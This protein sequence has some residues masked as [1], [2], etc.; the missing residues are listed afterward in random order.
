VSDTGQRKTSVSELNRDRGGANSPS[1][2]MRA[3]RPEL[4]S[5][6]K[7]RTESL[8]NKEALDYHLGVLT[9]KKQEIDFEHFC[10]RIAEQEI[11][12]N[13]IAQ[14]GPTGGGDSKVDSENYPVSERISI[15]WYQGIPNDSAERWAFAFSAKREWRS[16]VRADV[17]SVASTKRGYK[18]IYFITNQYVKD[19]SRAQVEDQLT[20]KHGVKV[21]ILDR[22]WILK[23]VFEH[24]RQ[25]IAIETLHLDAPSNNS[26]LVGPKDLARSQQLDAIETRIN[27][28]SRY[29]GVEYQ[30]FEDC[31]SA[32]ILSRNLEKPRIETD[33]RFARAERIAD[34][35][36]IPQQRLRVAYYRAWTA[37]WWFEDWIEFL[38]YYNLVEP[39][40]LAS[41]LADDVELA[42]NLWQL[43]YTACTVGHIDKIE[44]DLEARRSRLGSAL[45]KLGQD[46]ERPN[47]AL[48]ARTHLAFLEMLTA[49]KDGADPAAVIKK[50][51]KIATQSEGLVDYPVEPFARIVDELGLLFAEVPEYDELVESV[52]DLTQ[53][54]AGQER[55]GRLLLTRGFQKLRASRI[56]DA[57]RLFG[58]AQQMLAMREAREELTHALFAGGMAYEGAGLLWAAR[59]N[60]LASTNLVYAEL[61]EGGP[62]PDNALLCARKLVWHELQLGRVAHVLQWIEFAGIIASNQG[63]DPDQR[64][65][66]ISEREAQDLALALLFLTADLPELMELRFLPDVLERLDLLYSRMALL[67]ALGYEDVLRS[68]GS[69]PDDESIDSLHSTFTDFMKQPAVADLPPGPTA[70]G[71][72][73]LTFTS[74]VLGCR[75]IA[76]AE[77][78]YESQRLAE[79]IL[80]GIEALFATSLDEEI[81][82]YRE[83]LTIRIDRDVA[84]QAAPKVIDDASLGSDVLIVHGGSISDPRNTDRDWFL[85]ILALLLT[86]LV[87]LPEPDAY[88]KR[89]FGEESGLARS[90]NFTESGIT[91]A[92][93]L[94]QNPKTRIPDWNIDHD[95]RAYLPKRTVSWHGGIFARKPDTVRSELKIGVGEIPEE[96]LDRG[97]TKHTERR[98]SALIDMPLWDRA[99]WKGVLYIWPVESDL[100]PWMALG[101]EDGVAARAIFTA[102]RAKFGEIDNEDRIRISILT[103]V[104]RLNPHHYSV[105]VGSNLVESENGPRIKH[106]VS[107]SRIHRVEPST[108]RNLT[109]FASRFETTGTYRLMPGLID[110]KNGKSQPYPDLAIQ[111]RQIRICPAW[112]IEEHDPDG[113]GI[114]PDDKPIIPEGVLDPP[115]LKLLERKHKRA[116]RS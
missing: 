33:G 70:L 68:E 23:C 20:G 51:I 54:R 41:T 97:N 25:G 18:L 112:Q 6:S 72:G 92:N 12:P 115:V 46:P 44:S 7:V 66:F 77:S 9:S 81:F 82:P 31:L 30:L 4:F 15:R 35:V 78:D 65:K 88:M 62:I 8:L 11:C 114:F 52:I 90:V 10:R 83:E 42:V 24:G 80:A 111:K 61:R 100:E 101:F 71:G 60:T 85:D 69:I 99:K 63:L 76:V 32:A 107:V 37:Y 67:Y 95:P 58:R 16:K 105:V 64:K 79:R 45:S 55:A 56:Y 27:D 19:K 21:R 84:H 13:L 103:G 1:Q 38:R 116:S 3:R 57:I 47:N 2:F 53:R 48:S 14:T 59:A 17:E 104:D 108:S 98:V 109:G 22:T 106:F 91:M 40:A 73:S 94:G 96:V 102:W 34:S 87:M 74:P 36:G 5:D 29:Y 49:A 89:I 93:I 43:L 86:R 26:I 39:L 110:F 113:V 50:L 75:V 28:S